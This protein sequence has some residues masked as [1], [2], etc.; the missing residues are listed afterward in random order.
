MLENHKTQIPEQEGWV[1]YLKKL[2]QPQYLPRLA[3]GFLLLIV[4]WTAGYWYAGNGQ[5][6]NQ[7]EYLSSEIRQMKK[8]ISLTMLNQTSPA[9]RIKNLNTMAS[10]PQ[11]DSQIVEALI[12]T[13]N[14]DENINVRLSAVEALYKLADDSRVRDGLIHA[15]T[16]QESP[17]V[18]LALVECYVALHEK[19]AVGHLKQ[20]LDNKELNDV[21]KNQIEQSLKILI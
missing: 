3:Y 8:M 6:E 14:T 12:K 15:L 11:E 1:G 21:V 18:Q 17:L 5:N 7:I 9:E 16:H 20:L 13:L 4:G 10:F 2:I 19:Q